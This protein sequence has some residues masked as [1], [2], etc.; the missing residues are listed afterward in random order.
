MT[1][2]RLSLPRGWIFFCF[3]GPHLQHM[4]VTRLGVQSELQLLASTTATTMKDPSRLCDLHHSSQ[5][6][7]ILHPLSEARDRTCNFM[8]PSQIHFHCTVMVPL[9]RWV[10]N[11]FLSER[12]TVKISATV[13]VPIVVNEPN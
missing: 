7:R 3:L 2:Q 12:G 6:R 8:F 4:E 5:Q 1:V 13:G 11:L 9:R 10:L